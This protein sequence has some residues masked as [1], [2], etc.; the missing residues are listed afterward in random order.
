[1]NE[2]LK[3]L[4]SG[5]CENYPEATVVHYAPGDWPLCGE[6]SLQATH[7]DDPIQVAGCEECVAL[8]AED[9]ADGNS[10][11]GRCLHCGETITAAGGVAWRRAVRRPCP[12]CGRAGW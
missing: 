8:A 11:R 1:M 7:T 12:H 10:Y 2:G 5:S 3:I 6:E 4:F 9:L